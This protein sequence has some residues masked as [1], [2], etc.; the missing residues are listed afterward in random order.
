MVDISMN[1]A[2]FELFV[3]KC[4]SEGPQD[5]VLSLDGSPS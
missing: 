5:L 1:I 4:M 2:S 3:D